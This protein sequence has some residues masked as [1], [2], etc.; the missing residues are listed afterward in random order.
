M[1]SPIW[2]IT[3]SVIANSPVK[4]V[5]RPASQ[6]RKSLPKCRAR[7]GLHILRDRAARPVRAMDVTG[8]VSPHGTMYWKYR[9]SVE[10]F[11]AKPCEETQRLRCTPMA[12]IF[13]LRRPRR[14]SA[15]AMRALRCRNRPGCRSAPARCRG[16]RRRHRASIAQIQNRVADDLARTMISHIAAAV[17]FDELDPGAAKPSSGASRF[18]SCPL[19]RS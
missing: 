11:S 10:T 6:N 13:G 7:A 8:F 9:K 2:G 5:A 1:L 15:S 17:G 18:S 12:A 4:R 19:R 14:R 16:Q 3:T